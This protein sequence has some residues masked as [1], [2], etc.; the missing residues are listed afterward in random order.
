MS[1]CIHA[2]ETILQLSCFQWSFG[3]AA[4]ENRDGSSR[5]LR[6]MGFDLAHHD[7]SIEGVLVLGSY[8][9]AWLSRT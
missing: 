5:I 1:I 8:K 4:H 3:K 7:T 6:V 9:N 2:L